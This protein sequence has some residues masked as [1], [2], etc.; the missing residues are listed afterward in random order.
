MGEEEKREGLVFDIDGDL[1]PGTWFTLDGGGK[2]CLRTCNGDTLREF[3]KKTVKKRAEYKNNQRFVVEET[4]DDAMSALIWDY[5]IV[6]WENIL[7]K[8][9]QPIP[10]NRDTKNKLM[11]GSLAFSRC[12]AEKLDELMIVVSAEKEEEEKN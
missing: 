11:G 6:N 12:V 7:D 2:I 4:D 3:R 10:C 8:N 5:C 1:N 9:R